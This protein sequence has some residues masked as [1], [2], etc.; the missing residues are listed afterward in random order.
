MTKKNHKETQLKRTIQELQVLYEIGKILGSELDLQKV[1]KLILGKALEVTEAN[2]GSLGLLDEK[3]RRLI[4]KVIIP[5]DISTRPQKI[6]E[7]VTGKV[8]EGKRAILV[9]NV[10]E[11]DDYIEIF[12]GIK[13]ELA[14]PM[15]EGSK[16]IGV[17][18][19]E[20][21]RDN[22]FDE[23]DRRLLESLAS[24]AVIAIRNAKIFKYIDKK[25]HQRVRELETLRDIDKIISSTL[26]L[27]KVLRLIID[28]GVGL[29]K[30]RHR[31]VKI[32]PSIQFI[33][34][35]TGKLYFVETAGNFS[36]EKKA[37]E[38][39]IGKEG[40]TGW[41]MKAR[42][43]L[44]VN[45]VKKEPWKKWYI[46]TIP[47][48]RSEL[49][50][51]LLLDEKSIGVFDL[52][53]PKVGAFDEDDKRLIFSLAGQVVVAIR[54]AEQYQTLLSTYNIGKRISFSLDTREVL[55]LILDKVIEKTG[56]HSASARLLDRTKRYLDPVVRRGK[57]T[58]KSWTPIKVGKGIVGA[59]AKKRKTIRITDVDKDPRYLKFNMATKSE[60][61]VPMLDPTEDKLIGVLNFEHPLLDAFDPNDMKF[62]E[63][64]ISHA[65]IVIQRLK[66][67]QELRKT[68]EQLDAANAMFWLTMIKGSWLHEVKQKSHAI[69]VAVDL[70]RKNPAIIREDLR[71]TLK[72][73]DR[74]AQMITTAAPELPSE[75]VE[76]PI[77]IES[78]L[79]S[80]IKK[81]CSERRDIKV[82]FRRPSV[83]LPIIMASNA[84][85]TLAF[86]NVMK[87]SLRAMSNG[88]TL[89]ISCKKGHNEID[90]VI[91][92]TG[93]G[94]PEKIQNKLFKQ[95]VSGTKGSGMGLLIT[96][97]IMLKYGGNI[98]C[99]NPG[100]QG[101]TFRL[102]LP[103]E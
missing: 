75:H 78:V 69:R 1:L 61:A 19:L 95:P 38:F 13:S 49:A 5:E 25:L 6:G 59:A 77:S 55:K 84:W 103:V 62:I 27:K 100:P 101:T 60:V 24:Y 15:M 89:S 58:D 71:G 74:L 3:G 73:I 31:N 22:G 70:M 65:V 52:Q 91:G 82:N 40:I 64:L 29:I 4:Y 97:N 87:N 39:E 33:E 63:F 68:R 53:S 102:W 34:K 47:N 14:V 76:E 92:D 37:L 18:N 11:N 51:P 79:D 30:E 8:A 26:S 23:D 90:I 35:T 99:E 85:L 93:C 96:K 57:E 48:I 7:G 80:V 21:P 36:E 2:Y 41:A 28:K 94:I 42:K 83:E 86:E 12:P 10:R 20:S 66:K 43:P 44:L 81:Y 9:S 67:D 50:V 46:E 16:L 45:D 32:Y 17:L 98:V 54:N 72:R 56:A 88:G